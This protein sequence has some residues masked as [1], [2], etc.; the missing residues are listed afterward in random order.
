[1]YP[2]QVRI[3][4]KKEQEKLYPGGPH[5]NPP[6]YPAS[7]QQ[8]FP[9]LGMPTPQPNYHSQPYPLQSTNPQPSQFYP[10]APHQPQD[11]H[12][13]PQSN[14]GYPHPQQQSYLNPHYP[15]QHQY[16]QQHNP[17][18][19][20]QFNPSNHQ[21][22][23]APY[24]SEVNPTYPPQNQQPYVQQIYGPQNGKTYPPTQNPV[25]DYNTGNSQAAPYSQQGHSGNKK[26]L[27]IGI[28]Y[29]NQKGQ[30]KGC[31]EDVKNIK[32]F[33]VRIYNFPTN[34]ASM[35]I[36]TD[37]QRDASCI[38]TRK[39]I[40]A[41]MHWLV[42]G[43][44]PGDSLFLHYSG[45]G[46]SVKDTSGDEDDGMDETICPVDYVKAGQIIDDEM[47]QIL[48]KPL[49]RGVKLTVVFDSCHSG[50]A[51]DLPYVYL[52]NGQVK[53]R[54]KVKGFLGAGKQL[55][56]GYMLFKKGKISSAM[57]SLS[58]GANMLQYHVT[59]KDQQ[60]I[61]DNTSDAQVTMYSGCKDR[62]YS[63]DTSIA[64]KATGAMSHALVSVLSRDPHPTLQNLLLGCRQALKG[65][66]AQ[67]PQL[68]AGHKMDM[69]QRFDI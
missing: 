64:G 33:L 40:I 22:F 51:L 39:N 25:Q 45:H 65:K 17:S 69:S 3:Q 46:G 60:V 35:R 47:H 41:S 5:L 13:D 24:L 8:S 23:N 10:A 55:A 20:Q 9:N 61:K 32:K 37:D 26:S 7:Q 19:F 43:A 42:Q 58:S 11:F 59:G 68:S 53:E 52:P 54:N 21:Q 15:P 66:Y 67:I 18:S 49:V 48:V 28:N 27:L 50:T 34:P 36:L 14:L 38:P 16:T 6:S 12:P 30:L 44:K 62:Q 63:A 57:S 2:G 56:T 29:F 4:K 31:I 1:M